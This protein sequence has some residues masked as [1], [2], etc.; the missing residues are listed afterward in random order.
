MKAD[1][2]LI[3]RDLLGHSSV[4]VTEVYLKHMNV[5][6]IYRAAWERTRAVAD[7]A[8]LAEADAEFAEEF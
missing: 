5:H 3:L 2:L 1:P 6:R 4:V 7:A 8:A